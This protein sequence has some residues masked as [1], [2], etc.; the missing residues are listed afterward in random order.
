MTSSSKF[1]NDTLRTVYHTHSPDAHVLSGLEWPF[2][3]HRL[4]VQSL[5][6]VSLECTVETG[7]CRVS[8]RAHPLSFLLL[9]HISFH[10]STYRPCLLSLFHLQ[11]L[12]TLPQPALAHPALGS[13]QPTASLISYFQS[14]VKCI[15]TVYF[16]LLWTTQGLPKNYHEF[17]SE[18]QKETSF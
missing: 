17:Q 4:N 13:G 10:I 11:P 9:Y 16:P 3:T 1:I 5:G 2:S 15:R 12:P 6:R 14:Q 18:R 7:S 8:F